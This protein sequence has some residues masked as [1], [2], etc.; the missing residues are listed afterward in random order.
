MSGTEPPSEMLSMLADT[1]TALSNMD[2]FWYPVRA[3]SPALTQRDDQWCVTFRLELVE[4]P[5]E[6]WTVV[7]RPLE[8]RVGG[9]AGSMIHDDLMELV[10]AYPGIALAHEGRAEILL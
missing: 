6:G 4:P 9:G 1:A 2:D 3:S 10:D 8:H 7:L 5:Q